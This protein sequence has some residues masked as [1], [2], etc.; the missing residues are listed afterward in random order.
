MGRQCQDLGIE[1]GTPEYSTGDHE[2]EKETEIDRRN[3]G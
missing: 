2:V 3:A 1:D